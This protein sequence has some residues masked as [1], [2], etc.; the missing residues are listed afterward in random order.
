MGK[1]SCSAWKETSACQLLGTLQTSPPEVAGCRAVAR[2]STASFRPLFD[3]MMHATEER[4][5]CEC[6][7]LRSDVRQDIMKVGPVRTSG[8]R[9]YCAR[10]SSVGRSVILS[11]SCFGLDVPGVTPCAK[12]EARRER[13]LRQVR[14]QI[15][16]AKSDFRTCEH[17]AIHPNIYVFRELNQFQP[18]GTLS[19]CKRVDI[20]LFGESLHTRVRVH[21]F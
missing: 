15:R 3:K 1:V 16:Q 17:I 14:S 13:K 18:I 11:F 20:P 10:F 6:I 4:L 19:F 21:N 5:G 8:L 7:F 2:A 12:R 9:D